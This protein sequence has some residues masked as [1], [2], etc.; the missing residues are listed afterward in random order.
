MCLCRSN[1][2]IRRFGSGVSLTPV[3]SRGQLRRFLGLHVGCRVSPGWGRSLACGGQ[4]ATPAAELSEWKRRKP[5]RQPRLLNLLNVLGYSTL[6]LT[7]ALVWLTPVPGGAKRG[8]WRLALTL[9]VS[10]SSLVSRGD[11]AAIAHF[12]A[13]ARDIRSPVRIP[14]ATCGVTTVRAPGLSPVHSSSTY[15]PM[16]KAPQSVTG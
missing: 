13:I 9:T 8:S 15:Q 6:H 1:L 3:S 5:L 10:P 7:L 14:F 2:S 11:F 12:R 4:T 16:V